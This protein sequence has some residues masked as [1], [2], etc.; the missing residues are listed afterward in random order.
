MKD[1]LLVA[2]L[3][4]AAAFIR[5]AY[6]LTPSLDSDEAVVGLMGIHILRGEYPIFFWGEPYCGPIESYLAALFFFF[7]GPSRLSLNLAPAVFSILFLFAAYRFARAA[8]GREAGLVSLLLLALGPPFLVWHSVLARGNYAE[9]LFLG[10][11][12]FAVSVRTIEA[13]TEAARWRGIF[14]FAFLAGVAWWVSFQAVHFI[15]ACSLVFV[16]GI[17]R[18]LIAPRL[19]AAGALALVGS[20][21]FWIYNAGRGFA[22]LSEMVRHMDMLPWDSSL[23]LFFL[24]KLPSILGMPMAEMARS[25]SVTVNV[26]V[27][28]IYAGALVWAA[29]MLLR[30]MLTPGRRRTGEALGL[31]LLLSFTAI[32]S[33]IILTRYNSGGVTRYFLVFYAAFP[34]FLALILVKLSGQ[35]PRL[36]QGAALLVLCVNVWGTVAG[37]DALWPDRRNAHRER[38]AVEAEMI[39]GLRARGVEAVFANEYWEFFRSNFTGGENPVFAIPVSKHSGNKYP[40]YTRFALSRDSVPYIWHRGAGSFRTAL[41]RMGVGYTEEG[42]GPYRLVSAFRPSPGGL[43]EISPT[44]WRVEAPAAPDGIQWMLD[45]NP[46][47]HWDSGAQQMP[48]WSIQV[49]L[50]R[51][52]TLGMIVVE[53]GPVS[54]DVPARFEVRVSPNGAAW[55]VAV[56]SHPFVLPLR[57]EGGKLLVD[58]QKVVRVILPSVSAR[59][60]EIRLTAAKPFH[61]R[62][63]MLRIYRVAGVDGEPG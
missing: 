33:A 18:K 42:V 14:I 9:N 40:T 4:F 44:G 35:R 10:V 29:G 56:P 7:L 21:L 61:W 17:G 58:E 57:W 38:D 51:I 24:V 30:W 13:R 23:K 45:G 52:E 55:D 28:L 59:F 1:G 3:L 26:L 50:G 15:L 12:L 16:V 20:G 5:G 46:D 53:P 2:A 41:R 47:T 31:G 62:V 36:A 39:A 37:A 63:S 6:L 19:L 60:V 48:G 43:D 25:Y 22:S 34:F 8:F 49:D 32:A 11:V 27:T 54:E